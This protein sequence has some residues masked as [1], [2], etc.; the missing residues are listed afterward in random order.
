MPIELRSA[1]V[2][3]SAFKTRSSFSRYLRDLKRA[4]WFY[5][6]LAV[7]L[8]ELSLV[9]SDIENGPFLFL[10]IIFGLGIL[11]VIPG[12]LTVLLF[13][14]G[15]GK[16]VLEKIALGIF[17]SVLISITVALVLGIGPFFR[18]S[19]TVILLTT[20]VVLTDLLATYRSYRFLEAGL[21]TSSADPRA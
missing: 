7:A 12:L 11:G 6:V 19:N 20:Y 9:L 13:F 4:W 3:N 8:G 15:Q 2:V 18:A 14:P 21:A 17:L 5:V 16:S 10:R 1:G